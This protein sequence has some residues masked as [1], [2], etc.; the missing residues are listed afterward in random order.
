[1]ANK[2]FDSVRNHLMD[3]V[4][5]L[6][7][8]MGYDVLHTNSNEICLPIISNDENKEEGY[9]VVTFKVPSGS[10]DGEP[11]DGYLVAQDFADRQK[12]KAEKAEKAKAEK[13]QKI[14]RDEKMRA[15]KARLKAERE[16][17]NA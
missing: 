10:R 17:A 8:G 1:M 15:E 9:L 16:K 7:E 13:A 14:A 11:Y 3:C 4:G 12:V 2:Q 6:F 5:V